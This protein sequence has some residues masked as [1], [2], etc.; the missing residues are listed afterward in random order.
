M[1]LSSTSTVF[2][3]KSL[4]QWLEIALWI[5]VIIFIGFI[6]YRYQLVSKVIVSKPPPVLGHIAAEKALL[7]MPEKLPENF[8][9]YAWALW[10]TDKQLEALSLLYRGSLRALATEQ[11][12]KIDES[13]TERECL[14][15]VQHT[16]LPKVIAHFSQI[17]QMWQRAAY[18]QQFPTD[19]QVKILC[20]TWAI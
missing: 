9:Q 19:E 5:T 14:R 13:M 15:Q 17:M 8:T 12:L 7:L 2:F 4:A 3:A 10:Q 11:S 20:E 1:E 16:Q 6:I 18:A